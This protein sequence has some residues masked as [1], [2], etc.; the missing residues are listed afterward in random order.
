MIQMYRTFLVKGLLKDPTTQEITGFDKVEVL[1]KDVA[2]EGFEVTEERENIQRDTFE[3][4]KANN[5]SKSKTMTGTLYLAPEEM[6]IIEEIFKHERELDATNG[7]ILDS[8][9]MGYDYKRFSRPILLVPVNKLIGIIP[10]KLFFRTHPV[11]VDNNVKS[12]TSDYYKIQVTYDIY[13]V[14]DNGKNRFYAEATLTNPTPELALAKKLDSLATSLGV[15]F[16]ANPN[17]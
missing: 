17:A 9:E 15:D 16:F 14:Y 4:T 6:D 10:Y 3:T 11:N 7:V 2:V 12:N 13:D 5:Y 1:P 8:F